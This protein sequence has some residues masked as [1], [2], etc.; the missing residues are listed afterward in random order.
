[1]SIDNKLLGRAVRSVRL[2]RDMTQEQLA[3][4]AG[5][6]P[7]SIAILERGERGFT[8]KNLNAIAK[9]LHLPPACLTVL[10]SSSPGK[11]DPLGAE[12]LQNVQDL[13]MAGLKLGTAKPVKRR[14]ASA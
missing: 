7:N 10:G 2:T 12:L 13:I 4:K 14:K 5:M 9:A 6:A 3:R 8:A 11:N 1:M